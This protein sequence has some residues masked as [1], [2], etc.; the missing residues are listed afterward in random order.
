MS[1][2]ELITSDDTLD[3]YVENEL[4]VIWLPDA[5][6]VVV[7]ARLWAG[8]G[9]SVGL[10]SGWFRIVDDGEL[11]WPADFLSSSFRQWSGIIVDGDSAGAAADVYVVNAGI[12][13]LID[14]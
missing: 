11:W 6:D 13:L 4:G 2:V 14:A 7:C 9:T 12:S 3:A 1:S 10:L 5:V 8:I